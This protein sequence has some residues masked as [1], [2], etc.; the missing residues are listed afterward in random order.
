[1][2]GFIDVFY[3][4]LLLLFLLLVWNFLHAFEGVES[5]IFCLPFGSCM[6]YKGTASEMFK[7]I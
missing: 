4:L 2:A 6:V 1:M 7:D 3:L 5:S